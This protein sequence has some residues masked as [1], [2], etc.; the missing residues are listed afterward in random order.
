M[1]TLHGDADN[2]PIDDI[3]VSIQR[4]VDQLEAIRDDMAK[5]RTL[6]VEQ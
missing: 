6:D 5:A 2:A 3:K 1:S 4:A